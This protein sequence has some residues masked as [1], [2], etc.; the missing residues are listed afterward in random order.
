MPTSRPGLVTSRSTVAV[1]R[2]APTLPMLESI[3]M[4]TA[5][6]N[7]LDMSI[8]SLTSSSLVGSSAATS[9]VAPPWVNSSSLRWTTSS[10][11][12]ARLLTG[13]KTDSSSV[14]FPSS[15]ATPPRTSSAG[16]L[17]RI[18]IR[19]AVDIFRRRSLRSAT[20]KLFARTV[21]STSDSA[22]PSVIPTVPDM[23]RYP[24]SVNPTCAPQGSARTLSFSSSSPVGLKPISR[25]RSL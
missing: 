7:G 20:Q 25:C 1:D 16:K 9:D 13:R 2:L 12:S 24:V 10:G 18:L 11:S 19:L 3:G 8:F 15:M 23:L 17:P 5:S 22:Y 21:K 6:R 4:V 14:S